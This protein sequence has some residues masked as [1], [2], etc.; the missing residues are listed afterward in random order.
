VPWL[1]GCQHKQLAQR[2][3]LFSAAEVAARVQ[4]ESEMNEQWQNQRFE[5][6]QATLGKPILVMTIPGGGNPPSFAAVYGVDPKTGCIDAFAM[7]FGEQPTV[8]LYH[9][10]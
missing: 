1:T 7:N 9:C 5:D 10:R 2:H 6:L 4:R 3:P 8:R